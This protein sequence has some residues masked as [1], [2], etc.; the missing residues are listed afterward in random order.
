MKRLLVTICLTCTFSLSAL[1]GEIPSVPGPPPPD[2][3]VSALM[4][5]PTQPGDIPS[6]DCVESGALLDLIDLMLVFVF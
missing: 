1:G 5:T 2:D 3:Q 6:V 4:V